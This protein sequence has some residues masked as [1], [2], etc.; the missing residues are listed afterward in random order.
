MQ[1][2]RSRLRRNKLL[3]VPWVLFGLFAAGYIGIITIGMLS[4]LLTAGLF[5]HDSQTVGQG[6]PV[7]LDFTSQYLVEVEVKTASIGNLV[8]GF[9]DL[10]AET[11]V[12]NRTISTS[13]CTLL[14]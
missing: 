8:L 1:A 3:V 13:M 14:I 4:Q 5:N 2:V 12:L 10:K 7:S 11:F 6:G 9:L